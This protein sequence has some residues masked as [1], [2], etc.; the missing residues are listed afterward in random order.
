MGFAALTWDLLVVDEAHTLT[1]GS[2]R[3]A[4]ASDIARRSHRVVL[5]TAT[6]HDGRDHAFRRCATWDGC[7]RRDVMAVFRRRE[8][9]RAPPGGA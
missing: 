9:R 3:L 1:L 7:R 4:A 8:T 5:L 2:D 6:P